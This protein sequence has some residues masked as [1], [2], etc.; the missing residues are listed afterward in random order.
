MHVYIHVL[1]EPQKIDPSLFTDLMMHQLHTE[2]KDSKRYYL[3]HLLEHPSQ[4]LASHKKNT[5]RQ[6]QQETTE[7]SYHHAK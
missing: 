4:P 7:P 1:P 6:I 5:I 3:F 2:N